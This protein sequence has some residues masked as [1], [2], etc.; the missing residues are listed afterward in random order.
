MRI[1][2]HSSVFKVFFQALLSACTA[3]LVVLTVPA[4]AAGSPYPH[5]ALKD[6]PASLRLE[7]QQQKPQMNRES[8]CAAAFDSHSQ[9]DK[10]TLM[11]S[12]YIRMA[13]EG[14]RRS[15][16]YCEEKRTELKIHAPCKIVVEE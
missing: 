1:H 3:V 7:Y 8:R 16:H 4:L 6:L 13:A 14:E 10:M 9:V 11:C 2:Q 5:V 12:I 15:M